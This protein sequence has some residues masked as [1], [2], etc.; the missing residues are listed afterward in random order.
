MHFDRYDMHS[1]YHT[2]IHGINAYLRILYVVSY[3]DPNIQ[4]QI[5]TLIKT[6]DIAY[7]RQLENPLR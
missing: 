7:L 3:H 4:I 2:Y 1:L 5:T 6:A